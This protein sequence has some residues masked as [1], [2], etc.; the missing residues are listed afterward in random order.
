MN[1]K[2]IAIA[3]GLLLAPALLTAADAPRRVERIFMGRGIEPGRTPVKPH[4]FP[5]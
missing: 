3:S 1:T 4:L 5:S 2:A